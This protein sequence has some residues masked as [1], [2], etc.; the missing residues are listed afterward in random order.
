MKID[1]IYIIHYKKLTDRKEYLDSILKTFNIDYEYIDCFDREIISKED[2][3]L[4]YN[5]TLELWNKR[6]SNL[7]RYNFE[8]RSLT[9]PEVCNSLSHLK[10][11]EHV[12]NEDVENVLVIED[13]AVFCDNFI[14]KLNNILNLLPQDYNMLFLSTYKSVEELEIGHLCPKSIKTDTIF[15][16][17]HPSTRTVDS[18][19]INK[20]SAKILYDNI[21]SIILP[22]DFELNFFLK[23][24]N[25]NVW[26]CKDGLIN[27]GS[28]IGK[29][30]SS[31]R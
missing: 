31:I 15:I 10:A 30:K 8:Y 4:Y 18:Y 23:E 2:V 29:Y 25:F 3:L 22:F 7:Y 24:L 6:T 11:L 14:E 20:T 26:W 5:P 9:L 13:D 28:S 12:I 27:Q 1:K 19:V 16:K 17:N 21:K